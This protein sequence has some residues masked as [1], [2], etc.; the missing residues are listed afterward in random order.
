MGSD[1]IKLPIIDF[2]NLKPQTE[3][4]D[5]TKAQV[6][7]VLEEYGCFEATFDHI[8]LHLRKSVIHEIKELFDLPLPIKLRNRSN[9]PYHGYVGQYPMVPL[10][11]SLGIPDALSPGKIKGFSDIMWDQGNPSFSKSVESFSEKLLE[12]D[13]I[14]RK[15]VVESLGL[16]KYMDEHMDSTDYLIR[17]QKYDKPR[18]DETELGL[19][20]HT[21]KNIV[22]ILYQ[23]EINGLEVLT[24]DGQ[25]FTSQPSLNSFVV[26][27][28]ESFTAWSNGRLHAPYHKVMMSGNEARYSIGLFSVPKPGYIIKAPEEM[29]DEE[30]PLLFK[31]YDHHQFLQFYYTEAGQRSPA[32]LKQYCGV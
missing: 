8:P 32:A 28:G 20:S 10:Y 17:L 14:V 23:N 16:D 7:Q 3:T 19:S 25:W 1:T 2:S 9:K 30:H 26:M 31:P 22:T 13:K 11:E 18:S 6:R 24:K 12:L 5:S 27:I 4:W 15:M 29:V 21:D